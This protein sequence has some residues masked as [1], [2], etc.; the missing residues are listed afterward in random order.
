VA[1]RTILERVQPTEAAAF[2][3]QECADGYTTN[4]PLAPLLADDVLLADTLDGK[5]LPIEHGGPM[6][7]VVPALYGWKSAKFLTGLRFQ[8]HDT[9]GFWEVRGYHDLGDPWEEQRFR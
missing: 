7:L 1:F 4:L 8:S 2:L 5:P 3:I 6:R 9:P